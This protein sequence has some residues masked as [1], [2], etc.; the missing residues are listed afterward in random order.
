V[1]Q[2]GGTELNKIIVYYIKIRSKGEKIR[3][4]MGMVPCFFEHGGWVYWP[5]FLSAEYYK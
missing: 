5:L 3:Y 1:L 2:L 4:V